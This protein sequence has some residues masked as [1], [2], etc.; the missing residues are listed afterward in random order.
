V[1]KAE[2]QQEAPVDEPEINLTQSHGTSSVETPQ[3][4]ST[5]QQ[6]QEE[7]SPAQKER[8]PGDGLSSGMPEVEP[9]PQV[10]RE[11]C[12][13][14]PAQ[15]TCERSVAGM[16]APQPFSTDLNDI[17]EGLTMWRVENLKPVKCPVNR[18]FLTAGYCYLVLHV[19]TNA[20]GAKTQDIHLWLGMDCSP[21]ESDAAAGL[22]EKLRT[23]L[24]GDSRTFKQLE[25][26][27]SDDFLRL[28]PSTGGSRDKAGGVENGV[29]Q[30]PKV[31]PKK[32]LAPPE[33][34]QAVLEI[35]KKRKNLRRVEGAPKP[36]APPPPVTQVSCTVNAVRTPPDGSVLFSIEQ[37]Q[38]MRAE[39]GIDIFKKPAYLSDEDFATAFKMGRHDFDLLPEW[40][41]V[42]AK[43][44]VGL[45]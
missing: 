14:Q 10:H 34:P 4:D 32:E 28:F 13:S 9:E 31:C 26:Q 19:Q 20:S 11:D 17:D 45:F 15:V 3:P 38:G 29:Q 8:Q 27:E 40:K 35:E 1:T 21:G 39:D 37:L 42:A 30:A 18:K 33:L 6:I 5:P 12:Q 7:E 36:V 44:R 25:K 2:A 22:A 41:K 43:K 16:M 23:L 24:G